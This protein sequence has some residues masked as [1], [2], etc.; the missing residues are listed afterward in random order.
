MC[1]HKDNIYAIIS[2]PLKK[3]KSNSRYNLKDDWLLRQLF[4]TLIKYVVQRKRG[5][6][7]YVNKYT[8]QQ[9]LQFQFSSI[10]HL[11]NAYLRESAL[12]T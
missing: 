11:K 2:I 10:L 9:I 12:S 6:A 8:I 5:F 3:L 7:T 4:K 1:N